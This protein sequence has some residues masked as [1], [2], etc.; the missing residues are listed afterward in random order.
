[1]GATAIF[2][3]LRR[4][5]IVVVAEGLHLA[6]TRVSDLLAG[7]TLAQAAIPGETGCSVVALRSNEKMIINPDPETTL[8]R[9]AEIILIGT[10]ESEQRFLK[11][12]GAQAISAQPIAPPELA[13]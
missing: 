6:E 8:Q 10:P 2:N 4:A 11:R 7:K 12:Y 5:G 3:Y 1:M 13:A 9:G